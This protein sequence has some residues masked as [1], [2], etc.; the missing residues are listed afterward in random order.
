MFFENN[1]VILSN[2]TEIINI[3]NNAIKYSIIMYEKII[4]D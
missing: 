1:L 2:K 4:N 3:K